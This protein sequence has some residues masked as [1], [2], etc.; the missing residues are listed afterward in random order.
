VSTRV[1]IT[2]AQGFV[3]R[4]AVAHWLQCDAATTIVG[5]GRSRRLF[6]S[7]T[8]TLEWNG[9]KLRAPLPHALGLVIGSQRYRYIDLDL[10][11][12][13]RLIDLLKEFRPTVVLHLA[14]ALRDEPTRRL[15]SLNVLATESLFEAIASAAI[16][17]PTVVMGS[18]GSLYG[19]VSPQRLPIRE[20]EPPAP[21]DPYSVSKEAAEWMVRILSARYEVP[22]MYARIFNV[23]GPGQDER[24]LCGWL[25]RQM[26]AVSLGLQSSIVVGPLDTTRDFIDVRDVAQA[27]YLL[28]LRGA[29]GQIYNVASGSETP[30]R[31]VFDTLFALA[32]LGPEVPVAPRPPRSVDCVRL[33]A[34]VRRLRACCCDAAFSLHRS[35]SDV[36]GY[37]AMVVGASRGPSH[38][39]ATEASP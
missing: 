7:F 16:D 12:R 10:R 30:T 11:D 25:A 19:N 29:S 9:R 36:L 5:L 21:F 38:R 24:H 2:G 6:R 1:L 39:R 34:D 14:G 23:V 32:G 13:P 4:Y 15:L 17:P 18:T 20:E 3:G 37:Y 8:H 27:L 35:L 31:Y 22:T 33:F 26:V 28:A